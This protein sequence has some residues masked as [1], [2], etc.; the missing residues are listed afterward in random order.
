MPVDPNTARLHQAINLVIERQL[1]ANDPPET[2]LTLNRLVEG[3][4][5]EQA[6][7]TLIG[8]VVVEEVLQVLAAGRPFDPAR[9]IGRLQA[10]PDRP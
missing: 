6:A 7:R 5:A 4:M 8:H 1:A 3:G 10:L 9:Y 2:R